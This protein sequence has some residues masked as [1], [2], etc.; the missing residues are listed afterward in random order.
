MGQGVVCIGLELDS[1]SEAGV[2][3]YRA[4]DIEK[5]LLQLTS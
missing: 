3:V 1:V 2:Q 4:I 5:N